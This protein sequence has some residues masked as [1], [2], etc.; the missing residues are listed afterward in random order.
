MHVKPI[1]R[2]VDYWLAGTAWS[3]RHD[4][5]LISNEQQLH[6]PVKLLLK[7]EDVAEMLNLGRSK[8][9]Q[10]LLSGE[11]RSV[12]VG[13]A[14]LSPKRLSTSS[15]KSSRASSQEGAP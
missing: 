15:C 10:Y 12:K 5:P 14:A 3:G 7:V 2:F 9:Y 6:P 13:A 4:R 8:L 1:Q 11:L